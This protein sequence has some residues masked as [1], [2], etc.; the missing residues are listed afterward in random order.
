M[1]K[2]CHGCSSKDAHLLV[3]AQPERDG[4]AGTG[5]RDRSRSPARCSKGRVQASGSCDAGALGEAQRLGDIWA[6]HAEALHGNAVLSCEYPLASRE[7]EHCFRCFA[8]GSHLLRIR[9]EIS[10]ADMP[11][12]GHLWDAG[13]VL[14]H[15]LASLGPEAADFQGKAGTVGPGATYL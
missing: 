9:E 2:I 12:G 7:D 5:S 13:L 8:L 11:T 3:A 6:V 15:W 14:A 4:E 1:C 10:S